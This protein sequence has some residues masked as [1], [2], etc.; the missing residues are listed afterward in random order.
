MI[1][2]TKPWTGKVENKLVTSPWTDKFIFDETEKKLKEILSV[3]DSIVSRAT[4][5]ITIMV[6]LLVALVGFSIN[7]YITECRLDYFN[8]SSII[9][10]F[11]LYIVLIYSMHNIKGQ[12]YMGIGASPEILFVEDFFLTNNKEIIDKTFIWC[13]IENY[14]RSITSNAETNEKR[15]KR[16]RIGLWLL[17]GIPLILGASFIC[18]RSYGL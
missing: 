14:Q 16:Y 9:T 12:K 3:G 6:G 4:T 2:D 17:I 15:W 11:Y 7:R 1:E 5:L 13:Q 10:I 18:C 8:Y